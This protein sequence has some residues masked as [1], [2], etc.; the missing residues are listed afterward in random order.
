MSYH[1]IT[2]VGN[3]GSD[4]KLQYG[5]SGTGY[6]RFSV[7]TDKKYRLPDGS[8]GEFTIWFNVTKSGNVE[9]LAPYLVKGTKVLVS[10][11]LSPDKKSGHPKVF[12][13]KA[14]NADSSYEISAGEII[15]LSKGERKEEEETEEWDD[16]EF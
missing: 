1:G 3:I 16:L 9:G 11:K 8:W 12:T 7:A 14:G 2:I 13:N 5:D 10:G 15:L 6:V 4:A